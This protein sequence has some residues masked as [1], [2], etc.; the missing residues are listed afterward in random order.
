ML[1]RKRSNCFL[2][3]DNTSHILKY[4]H[5]SFNIRSMDTLHGGDMVGGV[6][7]GSLNEL[8]DKVK[9]IQ[10]EQKTRDEKT[11]AKVPP[12]LLS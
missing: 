11:K 5:E 9:K 10:T 2:I 4:R 12:T 6:S 7:V 8:R 1:M 3:E